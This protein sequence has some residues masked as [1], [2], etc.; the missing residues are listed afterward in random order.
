MAYI[1]KNCYTNATYNAAKEVIEIVD[2]ME[3]KFNLNFEKPCTY[4]ITPELQATIAVSWD[5]DL[6]TN[7]QGM[8]HNFTLKNGKSLSGSMSISD[9]LSELDLSINPGGKKVADI[10]EALNLSI[11]T[12][13][14]KCELSI[15]KT[16]KITYIAKLSAEVNE[17]VSTDFSFS[18]SLE[19]TP[20]I[21]EGTA[22]AT[23]CETVQDFIADHEQEI[24]AVII[25]LAICLAAILVITSVGALASVIV[26]CFGALSL[27][28]AI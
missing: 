11:D 26:E 13:N 6:Y 21:P 18:F 16:L 3:M 17:H 25:A 28:F 14:V 19:Y 20:D 7:E 5:T 24:E 23:V 22:W 10:F 15:G 4:K 12:G 27:A 8:F 9:K 1:L 2:Y